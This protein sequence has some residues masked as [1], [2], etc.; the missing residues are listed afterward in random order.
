MFRLRITKKF[1][2][3]FDRDYGCN[4]RT[5]W[6]I[7]EDGHV[8]VELESNIFITFIK[9]ARRRKQIYEANTDDN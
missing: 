8:V 7:I 5:G 9:W 4:K 3:Q 2:L 1:E 6:S